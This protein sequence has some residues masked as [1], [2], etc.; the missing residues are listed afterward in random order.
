MKRLSRYNYYPSGS[1]FDLDPCLKIMTLKIMDR[2]A[3]FDTKAESADE[4]YEVIRYRL[5]I[6]LL[7]RVKK[8]M[9]P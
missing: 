2:A 9:Q 8:F 4:P 3:G 7:S 5:R 1:S 6:S